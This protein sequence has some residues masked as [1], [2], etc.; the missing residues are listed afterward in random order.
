MPYRNYLRSAHSMPLFM[1]SA[2]II[3][4][5]SAHLFSRDDASESSIKDVASIHPLIMQQ[6][7]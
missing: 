7:K 5:D 2:G 3:L 6:R 1:L 4:A